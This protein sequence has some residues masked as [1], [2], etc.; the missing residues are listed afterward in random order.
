M[1]LTKQAIGIQNNKLQRYK[2]IMELYNEHKTEDIP[3]TAKAL[4]GLKSQQ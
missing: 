4:L 3:T 1:S 2:L